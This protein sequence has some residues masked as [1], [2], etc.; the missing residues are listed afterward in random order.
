M[1]GQS[2]HTAHLGCAIGGLCQ[3]T[4]ALSWKA[5]VEPVICLAQTIYCRACAHWWHYIKIWHADFEREVLPQTCDPSAHVHCATGMTKYPSED[6]F[7]NSLS[8]QVAAFSLLVSR[9]VLMYP[10]ENTLVGQNVED[11]SMSIYVY[12]TAYVG[13]THVSHWCEYVTPLSDIVILP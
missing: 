11:L 13:I 10:D 4:G 8:F 9:V 2:V 3:I 5:Y 1:T 6:L 12:T 7:L